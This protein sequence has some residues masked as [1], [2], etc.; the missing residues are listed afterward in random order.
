MLSHVLE[1]INSI[2]FCN[3]KKTC[4][5]DLVKVTFEGV[6]QFDCLKLFFSWFLKITR[7]FDLFEIRS[8]NFVLSFEQS[9]VDY[10]ISVNYKKKER[11]FLWSSESDASFFWFKF[12]L[13]KTFQ[14]LKAIAKSIFI[15]LLGR[16][17]FH[18]MSRLSKI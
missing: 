2:K 7:F 5:T 13:L 16:L 14:S 10:K 8:T 18:L 3:W 9:F 12:F 11:W 1:K 17:F 4:L 15:H 6:K